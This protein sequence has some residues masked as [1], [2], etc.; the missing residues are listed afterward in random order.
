M[1]TDCW[2]ASGRRSRLSFSLPKRLQI[3]HRNRRV[4]AVLQPRVAVLQKGTRS[5]WTPDSVLT[6]VS[7]SPTDQRAG[8]RPAALWLPGGRLSRRAVTPAECRS[9]GES[10]TRIPRESHSRTVRRTNSRPDASASQTWRP[11]ARRAEAPGE[12]PCTN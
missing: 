3:R 5:V 12:R 9:Q 4:W 6:A 1:E 7:E 11:S 8:S 2:H 10:L